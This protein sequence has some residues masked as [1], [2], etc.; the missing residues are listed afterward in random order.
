MDKEIENRIDQLQNTLVRLGFNSL[1]P[2]AMMDLFMSLW[3]EGF[4]DSTSCD[5][6]SV[7]STR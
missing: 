6:I 3:E 5:K 1:P 2:A 7:I 4:Y